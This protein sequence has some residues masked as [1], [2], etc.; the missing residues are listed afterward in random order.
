MA[1]K[2]HEKAMRG[3]L[4]KLER[5]GNLRQAERSF[6]FAEEVEYGKGTV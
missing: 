3:A 4:M 2:N 5:G 1:L 6:A